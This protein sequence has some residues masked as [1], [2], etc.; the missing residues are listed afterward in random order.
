MALSIL[1]YIFSGYFLLHELAQ[2][3][4]TKRLYFSKSLIWNLLDICPT[5]MIIA[6]VTT[7]LIE[8]RDASMFIN[9][10]HALASLLMWFK[11][12]YFLR[13]FESTSIYFSILLMLF[14]LPNKNNQRHTVGYERLPPDPFHCLS[15]LRGG[16]PKTFRS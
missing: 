15:W 4:V 1:L 16:F 13:L 11:Y 10:V 5:V 9:T 12:F 2:L 6:V 3:L 14:R 8:G 7:R